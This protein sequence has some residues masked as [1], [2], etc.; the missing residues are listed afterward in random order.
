MRYFFIGLAAV[1]MLH[2]MVSCASGA[3][4]VDLKQDL[5]ADSGGIT[6]SELEQS[7]SQ[8]ALQISQY[9]KKNP[10]SEG[11]FIAHL[12]T[13]NQTS[14]MIP[15]E[16]FDSKF[17]SELTKN[18]IFTVR[19]NQRQMAMKELAFS[20]SGMTSNAL[21]IGNMKSPNFFIRTII[22]EAM[23]NVKGA[24]IM[25]QTVS[26]ELVEVETQIAIWSDSAVFRKKAAS[27]GGASW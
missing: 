25:E 8:F 2:T 4:R 5:V 17:V 19:T 9:F 22:T 14:E 11:I 16:F 7:A 20:Q 10:R 27:R 6:R 26:V 1:F 3:Q 13:K 23:F 21:S 18:G 24:R 15:T 12:P